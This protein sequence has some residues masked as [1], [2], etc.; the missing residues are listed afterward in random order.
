MIGVVPLMVCWLGG[1]ALLF[2]DGRRRAVSGTAVA[3]LFATLFLDV[4]LLV[5]KGGALSPPFASG[6]GTVITG[7][8]PLGLGIRLLVDD[9]SLIF[10]ALCSLV[11]LVALLHER[12]RDVASRAFP[13]LI[14]LLGAGLHGAFFT[15]DLFNFYVFF[16]LA[17]ITS[18]CLAAYGFQKVELHGTLV[19]LVLNLFGSVLFLMGVAALYAEFRTVDFALL[20]ERMGYSTA[21]GR[22]R[23]AL[24]AAALLFCSLSLK[25]GLFPFHGWM[26]VLY[27]HARPVVAAVMSGA[28][29]NLGFYGFLRLGWGVFQGA[30]EQASTP[31]LLL[32]SIATVYG[33]LCACQ[34]RAPSVIVAYAAVMQAGYIVTLMG[35]EGELVYAALLIVAVSGGV[36]KPLMFLVQD[37]KGPTTRG[38]ALVGAFGI[39]GFPLTVGFLAK[40]MLFRSALAQPWHVAAPAVGALLFATVAGLALAVR[41]VRSDLEPVGAKSPGLGGALALSLISLML[42]TVSSPAVD[43]VASRAAVQKQ[44]LERLRSSARAHA[45]DKGLP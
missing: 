24:P 8:W 35:F 18:F 14:V 28:L 15:A 30:R 40:A 37:G 36:E 16:E 21:G 43:A 29:V 19:Y 38:V 44:D 5:G 3:A 45:R 6:G 27:T 22:T 23:T 12:S 1:I 11:L 2:F 39:A 10:G 13:A 31:L 34:R 33:A 17:V 20:A 4:L 26:T 7:D 42:G 41:F 9:T 25:V 32:G